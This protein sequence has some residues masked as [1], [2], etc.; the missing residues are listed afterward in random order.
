MHAGHIHQSDGE[1]RRTDIFN[2]NTVHTVL[3][4]YQERP[5]GGNGLLR[6]MEFDPAQNKISVKTYSPYANT[7]ETDAD[8]QFDLSFNMLSCYR[9]SE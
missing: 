6:I 3:S 7:Y 8:S 1:A 4:D 5:G 2:G 9:A